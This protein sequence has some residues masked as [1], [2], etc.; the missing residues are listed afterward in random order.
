[1]RKL[2]QLTL[3]QQT[4]APVFEEVT[5]DNIS[6]LVTIIG[7]LVA[8]TNIVVEVIKKVTWDKLPTNIVA[9]VVAEVLTIVAF[10]AYA[11]Y[12]NMQVVWYSVVS[13][14][15]VGI[16]VAYAAMFGFDKLKEILH[17]SK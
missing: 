15:I 13:A 14:V 4:K 9:T 5:M 11:S 3:G 2:K 6:V 1:M 12:S 17:F 7:A 8:L 16:L 10:L